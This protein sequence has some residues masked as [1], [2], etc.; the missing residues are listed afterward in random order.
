MNKA[1]ENNS[2]C[3]A[4][5]LRAFLIENLSP[6]DGRTN[7]EWRDKEKALLALLNEQ[8][9]LAEENKEW[10]DRC[11]KVEIA[12]GDM[13]ARAEKAEAELA[14]LKPLIKAA[15]KV[16][17]KK[18]GHALDQLWGAYVDEVGWDKDMQ[19]GVG[20]IDSLLSTLPDKEEPT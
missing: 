3:K 9:A 8:T 4:A 17:K 5:E 2:W 6:A 18:A 15:G 10:R 1:K 19:D 11:V 14:H 16:D 13:K 12:L 7:E 20:D